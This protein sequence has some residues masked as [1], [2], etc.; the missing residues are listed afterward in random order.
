MTTKEDFNRI[1]EIEDFVRKETHTLESIKVK[2]DE[3]IGNSAVKVTSFVLYPNDLRDSWF[4]VIVD[5][6]KKSMWLFAIELLVG[7]EDF[8]DFLGWLHD[9]C[10]NFNVD[11][12]PQHG[13]EIAYTYETVE[14]FDD[15]PEYIR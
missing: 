2:C 13:C 12:K 9:F 7:D 10:S 6:E 14:W 3:I 11:E 1:F 4:N 5:G 8:E 15:E